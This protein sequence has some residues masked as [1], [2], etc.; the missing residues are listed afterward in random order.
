MTRLVKLALTETSN[1]YEPMP[2]TVDRLPDLSDRLDEIRETNLDHHVELMTAAQKEGVQIIGFGELFAA[3]YFALDRHAFWRNLA[4]SA[5]DGPTISRLSA[6]ARRNSMVIVAPIY[7]LDE[8]TGQRFNTTVVIDSD[9]ERIGSYRKCHIPEGK[10]ETGAFHET[11][12]YE[13]GNQK[14]TLPVFATR[15][16]RVGVSTC[17]DR[18]FEGVVSGLTQRGAEIIFSPAVTFGEKSERLWP[19]EFPV[20]AARHRVYIA[21]SNRRGAEPPWNTEYFGQSYVCGPGGVLPNTSHHPNLVVS[22]V[23]LD[24]LQGRDSAGWNFTRDRRD[25]LK[26]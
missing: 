18:H 10:N 19:L 11:F 22:E 4:E 9:G 15:V 12:Y 5:E 20:D 21:G 24:R 14:P 7:E 8:S 2:T 17:Y 16:A 6:E 23:D 1:V 3:P 26:D 13:K 25:D